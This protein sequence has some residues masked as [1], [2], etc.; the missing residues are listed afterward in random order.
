MA[1][2]NK[3]VSQ[4]RQLFNLS[5]SFTRKRWE[6]INQKGYEFAHDEQLQ[7]YEKDSLEE[8]GM[9][10]FTINRILPVVEML[11]FYATANNPRWQAIGVEG[12]DTDVAAVFSDLAD[13]VWHN[14]NGSTLYNNA[15][16]DSVTKGIGYLLI[17]VDQDADNGLGEV[18]VQQPEP[19]DVYIDPK[20]RDML[21]KD[22]S[23]I[24]IRKVLPKSHLM[25]LFPGQ[26]RKIAQSSSDEQSQ[27]TFSTRA[28]GDVDQKLFTYN[29]DIDSGLSITA[30]GE[31]DQLVEFFEVY[32]KIKIS[33]MSVFY[34]I[35]PNK[36]QLQALK[37]QVD[38]QIKEMQAEMEVQLLEQQQAME[39][40][41]QAGEMLPERYELEMR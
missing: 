6:Q 41:V 7:Q 31:Q 4:I 26:K 38:V 1:K 29:D 9:P 28:T 5:N 34:R 15:I 23:Y 11:N 12:S 35:P 8:Q 17:S 13:Y 18:V 25:K 24:M 10:T 16:N 32:E 37:Q 20:S 33:Y 39:L 21:F 14:S 30:K 3:R 22:A 27:R 36:E 40:A 19:F 2:Q